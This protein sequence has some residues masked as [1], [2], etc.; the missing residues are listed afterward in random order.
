MFILISI[1]EKVVLL[2]RFLIVFKSKD[3]FST[4]NYILFPIDLFN[5]I[6]FLNNKWN[7][8]LNDETNFI[9]VQKITKSKIC[10]KQH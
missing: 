6:C 8:I 10:I 1:N 7:L 2:L 9:I 5:E 4:T 3:I